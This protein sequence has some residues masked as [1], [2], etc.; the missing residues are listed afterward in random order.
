M[1]R[2][3]RKAIVRQ[4]WFAVL[5]ELLI[6][7]LG[8][9]IAYQLN[10]YQQNIAEENKIRQQQEARQKELT[11]LKGALW[12]E[13]QLNL[14]NLQLVEPRRRR[15]P[16]EISQLIHLVREKAP[17]D[18]INRYAPSVLSTQY[19]SINDSYLNYY[20]ESVD[21]QQ[22]SLVNAL[23]KLQ[24]H[25]S[26]LRLMWNETVLPY[27]MKLLSDDLINNVDLEEGRFISAE[28]INSQT[29]V[30]KLMLLQAVENENRSIFLQ[31]YYQAQVVDS[32]L[33]G[34]NQP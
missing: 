10:V 7:I 11:E 5:L 26:D 13:N 12:R 17:I 23:I 24:N 8:I 29:V 4:D 6:V 3:L 16:D 22:D 9:T 1:F 30:N 25:I 21:G 31:T 33:Q 19:L 2:R 34:D 18:S 28:L 27:R 14:Q 32:L 20:V 15:E